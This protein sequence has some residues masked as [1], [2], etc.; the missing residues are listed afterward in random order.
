[1]NRWSGDKL[2]F[3]RAAAAEK[4][5]C[6]FY[7]IK[8]EKMKKLIC[9][10]AAVML[11]LASCGAEIVSVVPLY[12][13][14]EVTDTHHE[15]KNEDFYVM[16]TY[17]DGTQKQAEDFE[18]EILGMEGGYYYLQFTVDGYVEETYVPINVKVYPSDKG[19]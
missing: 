16:V 10:L 15:F 3:V 7:Y 11:L 5:C 4:S 6:E 8:G 18:I 17:D 12:T 2:K 19:E 14:E 9:A 13:G 1:M